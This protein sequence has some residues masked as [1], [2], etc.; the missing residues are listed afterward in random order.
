MPKPVSLCLVQMGKKGLELVRAYPEVIPE[1]ELNNIVLKSMPM[2]STD[3]DFTSSTVGSSAI[4][5]YIFSVPS[6]ERTNIAS[7]IAVF[8]SMNYN[9]ATIKKLF[10]LTIQEL[11]KNDNVSTETLANIL[12]SIYDGL[13]KGKLKIKI[14]SM[15]TFSLE[16]SNSDEEEVER[17]HFDEFGEDVWR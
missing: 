2:G 1:Q 12:P 13:L 11:R 16:I 7:L 3:G 8:D 6:E 4:S 14:S 17:D 9:Q 15:K 5:G 10:T